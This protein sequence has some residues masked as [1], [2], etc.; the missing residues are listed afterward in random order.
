MTPI[1]ALAAWGAY[2]RDDPFPLFAAVRELGPVHRVTLADG[3]DAYLVVGYAEAQLALND[4]RLS[5][6]MHAALAFGEGVVAEG[7][8][9]L[10]LL[11]CD[12]APEKYGRAA[13]R[14]HARYCREVRDVT[15][16][17]A[18]AVLADR[19]HVLARLGA[20]FGEIR[21]GEKGD[22]LTA[23]A[24]RIGQRV[25][26]DPAMRVWS[27][28]EIPVVRGAFLESRVAP[29][30]SVPDRKGRRVKLSQFR[31]KKVL[32]VTWASW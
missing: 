18:Q 27:F 21:L 20:A 15:L 16:E 4:A 9:Q 19:P 7:L 12:G 25:I 5:K 22:V 28:G 24:Q 23:F 3:H 32:V 1:E 29:E 10:C 6:D 26:A 13:L 2:D 8:P 17:D 30:F 31:G 14:W 11:L